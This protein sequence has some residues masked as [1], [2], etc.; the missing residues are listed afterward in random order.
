M[1]SIRA[2][3]ICGCIFMSVSRAS[4]VTVTNVVEFDVAPSSTNVFSSPL[5]FHA[6]MLFTVN[7]EPALGPVT[8]TNLQTVVRKGV[9]QKFGIWEWESKV[10][11][12]NTLED[13]YHTQASIGVDNH[14]YIH[15]A[16]NMHNMPWQYSVSAKPG[17]IGNFIFKG[18]PITHADRYL[19]RHK[20]KTPFISIGTAAIPGNQI[21]YPAFFNDRSGQLYVTYRFAT[22]PKRRFS[23]R[24]F[25]GG[26][27]KY[28]E[29]VHQWEPIGGQ[30][31]RT[32]KDASYPGGRDSG[33]VIPFSV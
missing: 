23:A 9:Q 1:T 31:V 29:S 25:A 24:D 22:R 28:N 5:A 13:R 27:A 20:N 26:I 10:I 7:V 30:L 12:P 14:G 21:T 18:D 33:I 4:G 17:A 11:E 32:D 19:V 3:A 2:I 16:Y 15:V 8:G 6:G